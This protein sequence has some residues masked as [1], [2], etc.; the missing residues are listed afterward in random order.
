M[1]NR[2]EVLG[3]LSVGA[4]MPLFGPTALAQDAPRSGGTLTVVLDGEPTT[5]VPLLDSNTRTRNISGKITEGLLRFDESFKPQPSLAIGWEA[6]DD[7][8][9]HRFALRPGVKWH[10]GRDFTSTDVRFSLLAAQKVGPRGRI[11]LANLADVETPDP[12]T[13]VIVLRKPTPY[14]LKALVAAETPIVPAHAY[15]T[16]NYAESPNGNAP[17]GTGPYIL[18]EWKRGSHIL[19]RRNPNYWRPGRPYL[20]RIVVRFVADAAASSAALEAGEADV[21]YSVAL[22]DL[23]RLK[24]NPKLKVDTRADSYLNNA[25]VFEFNLDHPALARKE[26]RHALAS[27]IDRRFITQSIFYGHAKAAGSTIP[28]ALAAYNDEAPF[29]YPVD[30][31]KANKLL[32]EAGFKRQGDGTRL[33]LRLAFLPGATFKQ[34]SEYL[35][36]AFGRIGV[37]VEILDGDLATY[38][39]RV[40]YERQFD[41][42]LNGIS[43]LFDPTVGVQRLYWSDGI[44]NPLP[45]LNAAHYNNPAVDE[46]FRQAAVEID[47]A[48]RAEQFKN[49][50]QIVGADLPALALVTIPTIAVVNARVRNLF[51]S[52]D[53]TAGDFAETWVAG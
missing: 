37:K 11:T 20:D 24:A 13:A 9:R 29:A 38:I 1:S 23:E 35:R 47:E 45:Y 2:R 12:L 51:D 27:V 28:A 26:V 50:Q 32:D 44:K 46:L 41:L 15:P 25:Q 31:A 4:T 52:I 10:D 40:Y 22:P 16:Q 17:I 18:A 49:I 8:L 33:T 34:T 43:R 6:S 42:N 39:K 7:G 21:S 5:L 30:P 53:L 19:L 3:I 14:L 36:A 48:R